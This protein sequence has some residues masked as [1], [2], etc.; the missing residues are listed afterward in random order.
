MSANSAS[1]NHRVLK[2]LKEADIPVVLL[3]RRPEELEGRGRCDLVGIDNHHAGYLAT[4]HLLGLGARHI[5]FVAYRGQAATVKARMQG[6]RN[7][8]ADAGIQEPRNF[9]LNPSGP[10]VLPDGVS[11]CD[12]LGGPTDA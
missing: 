2:M 10:V 8:L 9:Y 7:A 3:D 12:A 4:N 6:Y 11:G 1:V 5:G